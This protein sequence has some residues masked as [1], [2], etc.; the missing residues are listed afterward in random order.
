M[1]QM[2]IQGDEKE[3]AIQLRDR[4]VSLLPVEIICSV[5]L[6][7]SLQWLKQKPLQLVLFQVE[8]F[9]QDQ[10][11][12][13]RGIRQL[14]YD[15]GILLSTQELQLSEDIQNVVNRHRLNFIH[16]PARD[17]NL[18]G[19]VKK[20]LIM[21]SLP[22]QRFQRFLTREK[23]QMETYLSGKTWTTHM[24]NL[25]EG[26]AY[27]EFEAKPQLET[28]DL[29]RLKVHLDDVEKQHSVNAKVVWLTKKGHIKGG[30]GAGV[31]FI[32]N[33]EIYQHLM[34]KM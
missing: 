31:M 29:V 25:S 22:Q 18:V 2:L 11:D 5:D 20:L 34:E 27:C 10:L 3:A 26:G 16:H 14:G 15:N 32:K 4:L 21:R 23:A 6:N 13:I 12:W 19:L 7:E 30:P 33:S 28:G 9:H 8:K 1:Y 17:K 24:Y